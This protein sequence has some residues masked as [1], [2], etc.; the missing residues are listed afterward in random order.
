MLQRGKEFEAGES[1]GDALLFR[2]PSSGKPWLKYGDGRLFVYLTWLSPEGRIVRRI[3]LYRADVPEDAI[4][5]HVAG[6]DGK[7]AP[8]CSTA[9]LSSIEV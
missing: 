1:N 7:G 9:R 8:A 5:V 3:K 4:R 6:L 2:V